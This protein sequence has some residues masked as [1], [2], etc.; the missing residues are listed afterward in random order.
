MKISLHNISR[1]NWQHALTLEIEPAQQAMIAPNVQ[2]IAEAYVDPT[3]HPSLIYPEGC[4][5]PAP[6]SKPVGFLVYE[7]ADCGVGFLLRL[8]IDREHQGQV[9]GRAAVIE[10]IRRLKLC[11]NVQRI[12]TSHRPQNEAASHLFQSL[13]FVPWDTSHWTT[14]AE[15]EVFLTLA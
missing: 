13:G 12:A 15:G 14:K 11:P 6:K 3:L 4:C 8:M 1:D 9:F 10:V 2:S 5:D 7:I